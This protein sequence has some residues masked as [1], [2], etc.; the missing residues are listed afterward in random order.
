MPVL[1]NYREA[2]YTHTEKLSDNVRTLAIAAVGIVWLFKQQLGD[3]FQIP[4]G[5]FLPLLLVIVALAFDFLQYLYSSIAWGCFFRSKE[6]QDISEEE[7]IY[8]S[9]FLNYPSYFLFY[10]KVITIFMAYL[11]LIIFLSSKVSW[12]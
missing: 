4:E 6:K 9:K 11:L 3:K 8:A 7:E 10:G 5:L 12:C 2:H 1:D